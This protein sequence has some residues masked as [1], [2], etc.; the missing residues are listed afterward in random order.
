LISVL[1]AASSVGL[2]DVA[3]AE[4]FRIGV[5]AALHVRLD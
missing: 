2:T 5:L 4:S 1:R 3:M